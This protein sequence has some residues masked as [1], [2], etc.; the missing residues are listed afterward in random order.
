MKI[1]ELFATLCTVIGFYLVSE[2]YLLVGFSISLAANFLWLVWAADTS[3][4]GI[5]VVNSLLAFS[6]VNGILGTLN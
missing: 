3:A 5:F 6:A 2:S 1:V 4:R